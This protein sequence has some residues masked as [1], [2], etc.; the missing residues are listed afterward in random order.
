MRLLAVLLVLGTLQFSQPVSAKPSL[1][2]VP[3]T[4]PEWDVAKWLNGKP[5]TLKALRGKVVIVEFFQLW[6]P[7]CS[8]FSIPLIK[9]WQHI[10]AKEIASGDLEVISIHTVFEGHDYQNSRRLRAFLKRK[11]IHH[12][13]GIDRH[14]G[15]SHLP[16]TMKRYGTRGTP[17]MAVIGRDGMVRLQE[18]GWFDVEQAEALIRNLLNAP[19]S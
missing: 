19:S 10:F 16:E 12:R 11:Q 8:A 5:T 2:P 3:R 1:L 15:K 14:K 6:C 13:V 7:G 9:R 4:A 18:F 17:E